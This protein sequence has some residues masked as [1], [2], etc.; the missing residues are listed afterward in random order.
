MTKLWTLLLI[1]HGNTYQGPT[2]YGFDECRYAGYHGK[3]ELE[4]LDALEFSELICVADGEKPFNVTKAL[5]RENN[6]KPVVITKEERLAR[7]E[8]RRDLCR[9]SMSFGKPAP[10]C[11]HDLMKERNEWK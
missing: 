6:K 5:E 7:W 8:Y 3:A 1:I 11:W 10:T 9:Q 4:R 2:Y